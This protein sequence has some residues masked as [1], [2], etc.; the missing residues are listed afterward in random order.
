[1]SDPPETAA[2]AAEA[3]RDALKAKLDK[4]ERRQ[5]RHLRTHF[6]R[7]LMQGILSML[8]P[9]DVV[10]DCG[11]NLGEIT[12]P[13]AETGAAVHAFEPDPYAFERLTARVGGRPNVTLHRAAVGV[14][15]GTVRL[16]RAANF[17]ENPKAGSVKSTVLP[18]GRNIDESADAAIEVARIDLPAFLADLKAR[19]G[20]I[21]FVKMDIE[22]A[23]LE[24]L[25]TL[26][27]TR[28]FDG[29]RL[30]VAETHENKFRDL[31]PRFAALRAGVGEAYPPTRVNLDWI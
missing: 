30:T 28:G 1:M 27:A 19:H 20:E 16:M 4:I 17:D 22:G 11:A 14:A 18:G 29:I 15:P 6:A 2:A 25:E 10:V 13:L 7:G 8:R 26:L 12:E 23:E 31:R 24:I 9:G 5:Q 21:A 3:E